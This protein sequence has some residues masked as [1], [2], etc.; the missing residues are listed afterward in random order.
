MARL[1]QIVVDSSS[2]STLA[3]FW[4]AALDDF[5]VR[6]YDQAEIERLAVLGF[7]P[8]T[9]PTVLVDGPTLEICFQQIDGVR[10]GKQQVHLDLMAEDRP[11]EV[12]RLVSL[13]AQRRQ[14]FSSHTWMID[15]EGNDFCITD[16]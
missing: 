16:Q 8:D 9:D 5:E 10:S 13:G 15:P 7:T 12:E 11:S 1:T 4:A 14:E 2:P 6:P 3:H